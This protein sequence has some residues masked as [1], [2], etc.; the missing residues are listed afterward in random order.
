LI[1]I[2][3]DIFGKPPILAFSTKCQVLEQITV[4]QS[5]TTSRQSHVRSAPTLCVI[6]SVTFI[7]FLPQYLT[8]Q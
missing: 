3:L 2:D 6:S 5:V 7:H 8:A 4:H 1:H